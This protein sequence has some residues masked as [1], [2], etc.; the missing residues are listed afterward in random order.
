VLPLRAAAM[1]AAFGGTGKS[2]LVLQLALEVACDLTASSGEKNKPR[3]LGGT[4]DC[5]GAAVII[6]AEDD[7][8][9][10]HRR[11]EMLD[12]EERRLVEPER[13]TVIP[14]PNTGGI[15]TLL[16]GSFQGAEITE[17]FGNLRE[18]LLEIDQLKLV[19]LDPLQAFVSADANK[20]P[21]A[22]QFFCTLLG[23]LAAETGACILVTHHFRKQ[24]G[25]KKPADARDAVRGTT[26]LVDGM[27]CVYALWPAEDSYA[28]KVC[29]ETG[30]EY[31]PYRIV[32]GAVVKANWPVDTNIHTHVRNEFGLLCDRTLQ[33]SDSSEM[34]DALLD[35]L[36][37][38]IAQ[39]GGEGKPYTKTGKSGV[40]QRKEEL[41]TSLRK[42]GRNRLEIMVQELLDKDRVRQCSVG[43]SGSVQWLDV[44]DG[45]FDRSE[46]SFQPS[47]LKRKAP[48]TD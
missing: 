12:P 3:L 25:I 9:E 23:Q 27:R 37:A 10:I 18:Q 34:R 33:L 16:R 13:L 17:E 4:V 28:R 40:Y 47:A 30:V 8:E 46:G 26:A 35:N 11:L 36:E 1:L 2:M 5:H 6:T 41:P 29:K 20:D 45:I 38:A 19:V 21:A 43:K 32:R 48:G 42:I 31:N 14:L 24:G 15:M 39:A 22:G 7:A 44:P